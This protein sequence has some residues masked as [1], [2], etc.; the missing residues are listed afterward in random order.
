MTHLPGAT[1]TGLADAGHDRALARAPTRPRSSSTPRPASACRTSPSSTCRA[2]T[3]TAEQRAFMIRPVVRLKDATRYIVA[4][5]H[6]V[7]AD[8]KPHRALAGV[9]GA[10]RRH[11]LATSLGRRGGARS[12]T[13]SSRASTK[14]GVAKDDLQIA[15]DYTTASRENN[16]ARC[17]HM[18]DD[19]LAIVGDDGPRVHDRPTVEDN[20]NPHIRRRIT[21]TMTVPLY[22]DKPGPGGQFDPRRRR[23]AQAERHRRVRVRWSTSPTRPRRHAGA[24]LQNGHGLLGSK[25]RGPGR[26]PGRVRRRSRTTSRSRSISIGM[27]DD[28]VDHRRPTRIVGDIGGFTSVVERQ[29]QGMLN[30]LLAMRMMRGRFVEATRACSSTA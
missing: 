13:T 11:R 21:G 16:T 26:L 25:T 8:G 3:T 29:H 9:P 24:L 6:V 22:L 14:A 19:A 10:A 18:R 5:R 7:D 28:D 15:W 27:A 12:T 20:P 1:V 2:S 30:S 23:A 4:I 17:L